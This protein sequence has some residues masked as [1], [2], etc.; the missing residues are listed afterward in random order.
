MRALALVVALTVNTGA[1]AQEGAGCKMV[2]DIAAQVMQLRQNEVGLSTV[3]EKVAGA[4]DD[5]EAKELIKAIIMAA[6]EQPAFSTSANKT[7]A[8]A[9]FRNDV[10]FQCYSVRP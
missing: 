5:A 10:E 8:V 9:Q 3:M 7:A 4:V 2:G 1:A 6:Y